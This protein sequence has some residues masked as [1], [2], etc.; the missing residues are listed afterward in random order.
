MLFAGDRKV[1]KSFSSYTQ[2][3]NI[4]SAE[5]SKIVINGYVFPE[6]CGS[7]DTNKKIL[8]KK[9]FSEYYERR[10]IGFNSFKSGKTWMLLGN[11]AD[12]IERKYIGYGFSNEYGLFDTTGTAAGLCTDNLKIKAMCELIE[13]N[14]SML[15]W[16]TTCSKKIIIDEY[17]RNI[18]KKM[19]MDKMEIYIYYNNELG[20]L[21]TIIILCFENGV[22]LSSGSCCSLSYNH[23]IEQAILE[24]KLIKTVYYDRGVFPIE[25]LKDTS[26]LLK[27]F[28]FINDKNS[29]LKYLDYI[30]SEQ[31]TP[32]L[33]EWIGPLNYAGLEIIPH[34]RSKSIRCF[35]KKLINCVPYKENLKKMLDKKIVKKYNIEKMLDVVPLYPLF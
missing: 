18:L 13:K 12:K 21:H 17:I 26:F 8:F 32:I 24:A 22:F 7:I 29:K 6:D 19:N 30:P 2:N 14:E 9:L 23:A 25:H 31:D 34:S 33:K 16:Y 35:S 10:I 15:F 20:N 27:I 28:N 4:L 1:W 5:L 11:E 3:I